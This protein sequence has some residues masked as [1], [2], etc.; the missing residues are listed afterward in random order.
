LGV[1]VVMI[2]RPALPARQVLG[3]V[4]AVMGWL[5]HADLGV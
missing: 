1:P 2:D 4:E 5:G 3:T